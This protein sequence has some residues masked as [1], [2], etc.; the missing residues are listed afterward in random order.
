MSGS[1]DLEGV[2]CAVDDFMWATLPDCPDF[3]QTEDGVA[4]GVHDAFP[5]SMGMERE[6]WLEREEPTDVIVWV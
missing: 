1:R 5:L 2:H 4:V 3:S 6:G